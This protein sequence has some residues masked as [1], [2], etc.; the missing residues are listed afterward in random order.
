MIEKHLNV[1]EERWYLG[2]DC[3]GRLG[4]FW[5]LTQGFNKIKFK[6]II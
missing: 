2:T 3:G 4:S 6:L 1:L 5:K